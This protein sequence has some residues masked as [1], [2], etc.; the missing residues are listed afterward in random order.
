MKWK[1]SGEELDCDICL[2][3]ETMTSQVKVPGCRC[4]TPRKSVGQNVCI[5]LR[6]QIMNGRII[7]LYEPSEIANMMGIRIEMMNKGIRIY[8]AH[9]KQQSTNAR[10]VITDQFEEIRKQFDYAN[11]CEEGIIMAFDANVHVGADVIVGCPDQQDWGGKLLMEIVKDENLILM[12]ADAN[13]SGV[14]TR[15]A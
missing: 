4:I 10:D 9:L 15:S 1:G 14:I 13:C 12:N 2:L 8:T 5:I 6:K 3:A 7:K 11:S